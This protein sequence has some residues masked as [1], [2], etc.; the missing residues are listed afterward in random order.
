MPFRFRRPIEVRFCDTD[1]LGHVNNAVYFSY[2]EMARGAYFEAVHGRPFGVDDFALVVAEASCRYRAPAFYGDRLVVEMATTSIRS[3]SFE[4]RYRIVEEAS[5]RVVAEGRSVQV[6]FD[7]QAGRT[8]T[9]PPGF[10]SA[11][12]VFEGRAIERG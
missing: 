8:T 7:H 11:I 9:F 2:F 4:A 10:R 5:G 1:A 3:R 12:E 6:A